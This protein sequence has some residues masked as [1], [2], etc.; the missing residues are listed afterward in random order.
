MTQHASLS[1]ERWTRFSLDQQILMIG[2]EM[3][4]GKRS[5]ELQ[6]LLELRRSYE[7][8]LR[9]VDLTVEVQNRSSLRR[10]LL[11]WRDLIAELYIS[12]E[13]GALEHNAAFR[14]LLFFTPVAAQ[15]IPYLLA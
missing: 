14:V 6:D 10:E 3:N 13:P 15:Q 5:L 2:N 12:P 1:P 7:R 11:R 9:L 4:R 8:V